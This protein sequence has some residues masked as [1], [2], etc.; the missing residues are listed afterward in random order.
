MNKQLSV[1]H[2]TINQ[3]K[4]N[5]YYIAFKNGLSDCIKNKCISACCICEIAVNSSPDNT[6][7]ESIHL[8]INDDF[9]SRSLYVFELD[10]LKWG[11]IINDKKI[12]IS[13][14]I[15]EL[16]KK[17]YNLKEINTIIYI[18]GLKQENLVLYH[19]T[20]YLDLYTSVLDQ[21]MG[22]L[23]SKNQ[24]SMLWMDEISEKGIGSDIL[25]EYNKNLTQLLLQK[26][27]D[28]EK[29][30]RID[31]LTGLLNRR[32]FDEIYGKMKNLAKRK[33]FMVGLIFLDSD[34]LK[35]FNDTQGH[36]A[37]DEFIKKIA[38]ILRYEVRMSDFISCWGGDEFA[39][40]LED[41]DPESLYNLA[42]RI[43]HQI[44][45]KTQG[46]VSIGCACDYMEKDT[47]FQKADISLNKA[48]LNGKNCTIIFT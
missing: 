32:G 37:G 2:N 16:Q 7:I 18:T 13:K 14:M 43:R 41:T 12:D 19:K 35:I 33:G 48:K 9:K 46:S 30:N 28:L 40:I 22:L 6:L 45:K 17:V 39:I 4:N 44:N 10:T 15:S 42:E 20:E 27:K 38:N 47:L 23:K 36:E 34:S 21:F 24:H 29:E 1:N 3:Q 8:I 31:H 11:I 25:L 26:I 5:Q